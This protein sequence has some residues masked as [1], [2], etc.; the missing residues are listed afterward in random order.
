MNFLIATLVII[1]GLTIFSFIIGNTL[2]I[3]FFAIP[4]TKKLEKLSLLK[5]NNHIVDS[6]LIALFIQIII[7]LSVTFIFYLSYFNSTF[8]SLMIGY[9]LGIIGVISNIKKFGLNMNNFTEYFDKN[10]DYFWP[11][12]VSKYNDNS[13][14]L[15]K[16]ITACLKRQK[17]IK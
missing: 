3:V 4:F 2:L 8:I 7:I 5:S 12:L 11:E 16:F 14:D 17:T 6:Y 15:Y 9:I 10:K 13:H 1:F